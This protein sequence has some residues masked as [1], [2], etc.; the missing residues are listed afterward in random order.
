MQSILTSKPLIMKKLILTSSILF[1]SLLVFAQ[2]ES[3]W[4]DVDKSTLDAITYPTTAQ[5]R[6]YFTGDDRTIA[7]K[8][9]VYYSRPMR[10]GR[11]IFGGL[12]PYGNEWRLGA[13]EATN[14]R[15]YQAVRIGE[16][17]V[18]GGSYT[19]FATPE[20]DQ[21]TFHLSSQQGIWGNANRD[22]EKTVASL[23]V[24]I[25]KVEDAREELS[26]AFQKKSDNHVNLVV[27]WENV[28][29]AL[30]ISFDPISY[31]PIDASPMDMVHYP[32]KSAYT[33]YLEGEEKEMKP[34]LQ[35]R[36]SRPFKK[37]RVIF[38]EL[39]NEG[40]IWRMGANE[41]TELTVFENIIIGDDE[42]S[43]GRY[44]LYAELGADA[45]DII[46]SSDLP[47]WGPA[48][49]DET[50]DVARVKVRVTEED[51]VLENLSIIFEDGTD[52]TVNMVIG[53]DQT[54]ATLPI[55][56]KKGA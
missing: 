17:T 27:A 22:A 44:A 55:K 19:V 40:D 13:N 30:P 21:W 28:E 38:G 2:D 50:K 31:S 48:N 34:K 33:N 47:S 32:S 10:K 7:P 42:I 52:G 24:P 49:R 25:K 1:I 4:P 15:F 41:S 8:I 23:T 29:A 54:R 43:R 3:K 46:F 12:V 37:D 11:D 51:E 14:I 45:W 20:A 39:L 9:R 36:Y 53:W 56:F 16:T 26:M 18:P 5:W 35:L 6:N